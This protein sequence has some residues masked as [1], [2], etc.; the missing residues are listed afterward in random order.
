[1]T[2]LRKSKGTFVAVQKKQT[3]K[4]VIMGPC[5]SICQP[6][7]V[8]GGGTPCGTKCIQYCSKDR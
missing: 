6:Y 8:P 4:S 3:A 2:I 7:E 1:M 5:G